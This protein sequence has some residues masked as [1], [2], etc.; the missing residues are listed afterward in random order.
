MRTLN[1]E[2][3]TTL[4]RWFRENQRDLPWREDKEPYH[5]W[6]SEIML[7]QTRVEA[8]REYYLR[9]MKELPTIA[10]L[11]M[12]DEDTLLKLWQG[13]GYYNR[14]RNMHKA[15]VTVEGELNGEFPKTFEGIRAL[16]GIG[17]YTAG[18]IGSICFDLQVPAVDGNVLRVMSRLLEDGSDIKAGAT[19]KQMGEIL[20]ELYPTKNCGDFT[21]GLIELGAIV[22]VPNGTP[23]CDLCPVAEFCKARE[24]G[25]QMQYPVKSEKKPRKQVQKA[26]FL[27]RCV[28]EDGMVRIAVRKRPKSGLLAGLYEFPNMDVEQPLSLDQAIAVAD[29]WGCVPMHLT[30]ESE[31]KHIFTHVEWDMKGYYMDVHEM[32]EQFRWVTAEEMEGEV[33]IPS[34]FGYFL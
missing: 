1:Q 2:F 31:Y 14:I 22:C 32:P 21:Q 15:A 6:V 26:V 5:V 20:R 3:T 33:A 25:T 7:Q 27:L 16:S 12:A 10:D 34:A 18:A 9:F 30:R 11:A 17:D 8:V 29:E 4:T 19:K 24:H 23:K 28:D 13:L